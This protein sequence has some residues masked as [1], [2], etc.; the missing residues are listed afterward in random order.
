MEW[1]PNAE[2][3]SVEVDFVPEACV[4]SAMVLAGFMVIRPEVV[5]A[6]LWCVGPAAVD[7]IS[8]GWVL[9]VDLQG[10]DLAGTEVVFAN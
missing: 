10:I 6:G 2:A 5:I 4:L 7:F 3:V 8:V 1:P 9:S